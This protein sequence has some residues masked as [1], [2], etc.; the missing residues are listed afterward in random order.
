M[1]ASGLHSVETVKVSVWNASNILLNIFNNVRQ[2]NGQSGSISYQG[3]ISNVFDPS[4]QCIIE[5]KSDAGSFERLSRKLDSR[6]R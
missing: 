3:E 1:I 6:F 5:S 4:M 2:L